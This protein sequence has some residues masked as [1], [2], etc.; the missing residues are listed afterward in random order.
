MHLREVAALI[1]AYK[2]QESALPFLIKLSSQGSW[3]AG[4]LQ[5]YIKDYGGVDPYA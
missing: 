3:Y 2:N 5:T 1:Y 4:E